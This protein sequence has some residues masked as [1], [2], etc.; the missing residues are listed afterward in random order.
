ML[1]IKILFWV[2]LFIIFYSYIGYG[3]LIWVLL[4]FKKHPEELRIKEEKGF[5]PVVTLLVAAYNEESII[6]EKIEN[7]LALD[8]PEDKL[9]FYFIADGSDDNTVSII[10]NCPRIK[11]FYKKERA[12]K[13]AAMNRAVKEVTT[14]ISIFSDAN[15]LLNKNCIKELVKHYANPKVGAVAGEKKVVDAAKNAQAA[16]EGEGL[17]WKYES[18]LKK[19][20]S[21]YNTVVGAAG[22]L[23]S[24]RTNLYEP[25]HS[26]ILLDDFIISMKICM[27]GY[28]VVYEPAAFATE[29]PSFNMKEEEKRKIRISAGGFQSIAMLKPLLNIFKYGKLSFQYISHRVLRWAVCPVLL[30]LL[31]ILNLIIV[32]KSASFIYTA[33]GVLQIIFYLMALVGFVYSRLNLKQKIFFIPYYFVFMNLA[34]YKGYIRFRRNKQSVLWEKAKRKAYLF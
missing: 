4:K 1:L 19:L 15:T 27:Q 18:L 29:A 32:I 13:I 34:L 26:N 16:G 24:V 17:Y 33:F 12:G 2:F 30:P 20:D 22:E 8:Y 25:V 10:E 14:D 9:N 31:F 23:F 28:K 5:E 21:D 3:M 6:Q 11:L 7:C